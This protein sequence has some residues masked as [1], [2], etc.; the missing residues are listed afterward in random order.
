MKTRT[1]KVVWSL[2]IF[3]IMV[4]FFGMFA[5]NAELPPAVDDS[6]LGFK[7]NS[8]WTVNNLRFRLTNVAEESIYAE[9]CG[10]NDDSIISADIPAQFIADGKIVTVTAIKEKAFAECASLQV[11]IIPET[12]ITIGAN[13]FSDCRS[14]KNVTILGDVLSIGN[15]A[16]YCCQNLTDVEYKGA[17]VP[18]CGADI[19]ES[20]KV[21]SVKVTANY[22]GADFAG[23]TKEVVNCSSCFI[24]DST[25][26][27]C[28]VCGAF[29]THKSYANGICEACGYV[30]IHVTEKDENK[31]TCLKKA[32]CDLCSY[33]YGEQSNHSFNNSGVCTNCLMTAIWS[34]IRMRRSITMYPYLRQLRMQII[35]VVFMRCG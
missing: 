25:T 24:F 33:S 34:W 3:A 30:C 5:V 11:V 35:G 21:K 23:I 18:T 32:V 8:I 19:F 22:Q 28:T 4:A 9:L 14:L 10:Y 7:V 16:F 6:G 1:V 2:I 17:T 29:C 12:V 20:S 31:A 26:G 13:A 15:Y 27:K